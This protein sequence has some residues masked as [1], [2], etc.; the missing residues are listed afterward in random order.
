MGARDLARERL[1]EVA[2]VVQAGE[3]VE[4]GELARLAEAA[5]VLDR[6]AG[7][8]GEL[9]ELVELVVAEGVGSREREKT[10]SVPS[11]LGL[12]RERHGQA[13]RG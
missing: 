10:A 6:R 4:V 3:R 11:V 5:C 7:A 9:L 1:V 8:A 2:P 12:G 13:R